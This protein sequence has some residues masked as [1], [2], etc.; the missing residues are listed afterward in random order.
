MKNKNEE[1]T[2]SLND[3]ENNINLLLQKE[4][5]KI[6]L[7]IKNFKENLSLK[8]SNTNPKNVVKSQIIDEFFEQN[9]IKYLIKYLKID[10]TKN[11]PILINK[12]EFN[13][14][15][16]PPIK[17]D[18]LVSEDFCDLGEHR[19]IFTKFPLFKEQV[20]LVSRDFKSQ[21]DH[22]TF[23]NLRDTIILINSLDGCAFFNGGEKAGASQPRKHLQAF[24]YKSFPDK[25][26]NFGIFTL[27]KNLNNLSEIKFDINLENIH[28]QVGNFYQ[29]KKFKEENIEHIMVKFNDEMIK[30][31]KNNV[32]AN[33]TGE[34]CLKLYEILSEFLGNYQYEK[35]DDNNL[36][37]NSKIIQDFSFLITQEFIFMVK[38]KEHDIFI[39]EKDKEK[40]DFINLNSLAYFFII[41]S[42]DPNQIEE[43][44]NTNIIQSIYSKL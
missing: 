15:F 23:E 4:D 9:N 16:A 41:V 3:L 31:M 35:I 1:L 14:P 37:K 32:K 27:V 38:R 26:N 22:L 7:D 10:N 42:R 11:K 13:D 39:S 21:Y 34:I 20:L 8:Y 36:K 2:K 12:K 44:K 28:K 43:L 24:P 40:N 6:N 5:L 29:I 25:N 17:P 18:A 19:L 30:L 33:V